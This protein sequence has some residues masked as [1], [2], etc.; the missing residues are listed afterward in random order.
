[1]S[2]NIF[3]V[4]FSP[5]EFIKSLP[6]QK[7]GKMPIFLAWIIGAVY[8]LR[9]GVAFQLG[10]QMHYGWFLL[11]VFII[12]IPVGYLA[13][14][15]FSFFLYISGK[16]FKGKA[17]F[18]QLFSAS[19]YARVP[20]IFVFITWIFL[21]IIYRQS[22]FMHQDIYVTGSQVMMVLG[23]VQ[24]VFYIW[25]FVI[26]LHTIGEVQQFSAW[27]SLWNVILAFIIV[28]MINMLVLF[29]V[30]LVFSNSGSSQ[31]VSVLTQIV[32]LIN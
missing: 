2:I 32:N 1:M 17:T 26:A 18:Q 19:C 14:Y 4:M 12:A 22:T 29:T 23:I 16:V 30:A 8:L 15:V 6:D 20:E 13:M 24:V 11:T 21:V 3:N 27:I 28:F 7:V 31:N 10:N 9:E 25:G 5:R